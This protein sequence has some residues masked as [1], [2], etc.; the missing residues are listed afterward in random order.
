MCDPESEHS[1]SIETTTHPGQGNARPA[2]QNVLQVSVFQT[3]RIPVK[4]TV[5]VESG[6]TASAEYISRCKLQTGNLFHLHTH[7]LLDQCIH[8]PSEIHQDL[9]C[10]WGGLQ[11]VPTSQFW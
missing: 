5:W 9:G 7:L 10:F 6:R 8:P 3:R 4:G 2:A 1:P 11:G